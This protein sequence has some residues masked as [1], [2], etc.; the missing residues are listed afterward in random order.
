MN[1]DSLDFLKE[2]ELK[3]PHPYDS[4]LVEPLILNEEHL[5]GIV[6]LPIFREHHFQL[7]S[8]NL[9]IGLVNSLSSS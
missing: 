6:E 2:P 5:L 8:G 4:I 3:V 1:F 9:K 7:V